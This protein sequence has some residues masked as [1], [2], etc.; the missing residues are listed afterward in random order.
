M[1][2]SGENPDDRW[3]STILLSGIAQNTKRKCTAGKKRDTSFAVLK[4]AV[5]AFVNLV[6]GASVPSKKDAMD[7]D[8]IG[9]K[10]GEESWGKEEWWGYEWGDSEE[11]QRGINSVRGKGKGPKGSC[12]NCQGDNFQRD[13]PKVGKG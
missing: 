11:D 10:E 12:Y 6:C 1:E 5:M 13:C 3:V 7:I 8:Q 9:E 4:T 2:T